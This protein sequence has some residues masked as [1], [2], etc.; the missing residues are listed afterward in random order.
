MSVEGQ[1]A[2]C[3][4]PPRARRHPYTQSGTRS[5]WDR[6]LCADAPITGPLLA[7]V[8]DLGWG[9]TD[10]PEYMRLPGEFRDTGFEA[11]SVE[12]HPTGG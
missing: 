2:G 10:G 8:T 12:A 5:H 3:L 4:R 1:K 9:A 6:G 11:A 7:G